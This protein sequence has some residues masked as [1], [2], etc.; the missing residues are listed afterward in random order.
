MTDTISRLRALLTNHNIDGYII[1]RTDEYQNEYT[2]ECANRLEYM[3]GFNGSSG[4]AIITK[5]AKYFWTDGRYVLQ[6]AK[7][8]PDFTLCSRDFSEV[9]ADKILAQPR[10]PGL[11]PGSSSLSNVIIKELGPRFHGDDGI[12]RIGYNP[13]LF[14]GPQLDMLS[15]KLELVPIDG[16]LIDQIWPSKPAAP[17]T[18]VYLYPLEYSGKEASVKLAEIKAV[19]SRH[20][21]LDPGPSSLNKNIILKNTLEKDGV[22]KGL[23][24]G[25]RRDDGFESYLI[26]SPD[27]I[28]WLLN[29]RASDIEHVPVMLCYAIISHDKMTVFTDISRITEDV[30]KHLNFVEFRP[31]E[32]IFAALKSAGKIQF[33]PSTCPIA[34]VNII[35]DKLEAMNPCLI[36]KSCKNDTEIEYT[37]KGHIKDAVA[38]CEG[39]AWTQKMRGIREYDICLKLTELRAKQ[40]GYVMD[41]FHTTAAF[42]ENGAV[43]HYRPPSEDSKIIDNDGLLL[44]DSGGHYLGCT[45]DVTRVLALGKP[46]SEQKT[47]YTQVLKGHIALAMAR[48]PDNT[49]GSNLDILTRQFLWNDGVDYAHGTGHGVSNMLSVHESPGGYI[50]QARTAVPMKAGMISSNEPGFYKNGEFGIRI[51]NLMFTKPAVQ[52]GFLEFEML[53]LVPYARDLIDMDMMTDKEMGYLRNYYKK[54]RDRVLPLLSLEAKMW[55]EYEMEI[56]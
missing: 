22:I 48:F 29:I 37:K 26:T 9:G 38:L 34:F 6:A 5:D 19:L 51:E 10:H 16:D 23:D 35:H 53:T 1:P 55:C 50:G 41:S 54:I 3:T 18:N 12:V 32:D 45:T 33:D 4:I 20:P 47:R 36:P 11:D 44:I 28:C 52:K 21:G 49:F 31:T 24:P 13:M 30:K 56:V 17:K 46:T 7:E 15:K 27:S 42:R 40:E 2:P 25:F 8:V 43:I 39:L 14:T